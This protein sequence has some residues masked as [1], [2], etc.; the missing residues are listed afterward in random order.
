MCLFSF[1]KGT[2]DATVRRFAQASNEAVDSAAVRERF[3]AIGVTIPSADRP[4]PEYMKKFVPSERWSGPIKAS[5]VS[6]D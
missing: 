4:T 6:A 2:L 3:K 1:P 5:G